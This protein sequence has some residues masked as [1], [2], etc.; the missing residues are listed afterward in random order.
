MKNEII[1]S[2]IYTNMIKMIFPRPV[3][4]FKNYLTRRIIRVGSKWFG[5]C[6]CRNVTFRLNVE[7]G[8]G[9]KKKNSHVFQEIDS[10]IRNS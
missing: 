9:E 8:Y 7:N 1:G 4:F 6:S 5:G 2:S 10:F 3:L